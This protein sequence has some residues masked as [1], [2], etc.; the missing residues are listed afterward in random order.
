MYCGAEGLSTVSGTCSAGYFCKTN[1]I[2]AAPAFTDVS[3]NYGLCPV[4]YY[5]A[6]STSTPTACLAGTYYQIQIWNNNKKLHLLLTWSLTG[7]TR[8]LIRLFRF[9]N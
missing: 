7:V 9:R 3:G 6:S 4:G 5:C 2:Y 1:A 8:I